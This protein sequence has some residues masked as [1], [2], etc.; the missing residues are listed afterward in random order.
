MPQ[1]RYQLRANQVSSVVITLLANSTD[2]VVVL[3]E[4]TSVVRLRT[5]IADLLMSVEEVPEA[6]GTAAPTVTGT[7]AASAFKK[8]I[9]IPANET[10]EFEV[11]EGLTELHFRSVAGG[12]VTVTALERE[13]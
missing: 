3:P 4:G 9:P 5:A 13:L 11:Q 6:V 2:V 10:T 8:N 12:T 7:V 1:V